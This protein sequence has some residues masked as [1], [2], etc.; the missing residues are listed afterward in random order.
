M[1]G[2]FTSGWDNSSANLQNNMVVSRKAEN[3]YTL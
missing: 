3:V 2:N 1:W